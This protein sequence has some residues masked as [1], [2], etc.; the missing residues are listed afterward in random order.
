MGPGVTGG[1]LTTAL[2]FEGPPGAVFPTG[3]CPW[4]GVSGA[5][6]LAHCHRHCLFALLWMWSPASEGGWL[7]SV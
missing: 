3:V 5:G 1:M 4:V 7:G 6:Q 2:H